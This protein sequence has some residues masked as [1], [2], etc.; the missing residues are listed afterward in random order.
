MTSFQIAI[1][2]SKRA[3]GRFIS[4]VR[5]ALQRALV[6]EQAASGI[7]QSAVAKAIGVH[8]SVISRELN[9][10][11]DITLGRVAELAWS[12][13]R[14]IDFQLVKPEREAGLNAPL[15]KPGA[16]STLREPNAVP[17]A[18]GTRAAESAMA[19]A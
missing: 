1:S 12:M 4:K 15:V 18:I 9:G 2:P 14:E 5:R 11:Q 19:V 7:N 6:E 17:L 3:A 13:G 10:R 16:L 8:R